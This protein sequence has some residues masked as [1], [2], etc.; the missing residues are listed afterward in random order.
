MK[1]NFLFEKEDEPKSSS[2]I[3]KEEIESLIQFLS[4]SPEY[5]SV[6]LR[7]DKEGGLILNVRITVKRNSTIQK[8]M[9]IPANEDLI[10]AVIYGLYGNLSELEKY[11][12]S[13]HN[14]SN[15]QDADTVKQETFY[16]LLDSP[17]KLYL[18]DELVDYNGERY[19]TAYFQI[20]HKKMFNI[21]LKKT[22]EINNK[23]N[24]VV[25][26]TDIA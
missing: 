12:E 17:F 13:E 19:I 26:K 8:E 23:I 20:A 9:I 6:R 3:S 15:S 25:S 11:G 2:S 21:C 4:A 16:A 1:L 7:K 5:V 10:Q 18:K 14:V 22:E 24:S